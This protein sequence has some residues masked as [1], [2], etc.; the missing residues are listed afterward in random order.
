MVYVVKKHS[1][2]EIWLNIFYWIQMDWVTGITLCKPS[3][4]YSQV[5][6]ISSIS[7]EYSMKVIQGNVIDIWCM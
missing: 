2:S 4:K 3:P 7:I 1:S 5:D 6:V